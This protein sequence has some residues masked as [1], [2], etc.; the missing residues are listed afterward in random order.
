M[1]TNRQPKIQPDLWPDWRTNKP[2]A[3]AL[4]LTFAFLIVFLMAK[5]AESLR[6]AERIGK[7]EPYEHQITVDGVGKATSLS[8]ADLGELKD[9]ARA[10]AIA[11]AKDK[12]AAISQTLGVQ[13]ERV[14]GYSE[15]TDDGFLPYPFY[16]RADDSAGVLPDAET[17]KDEVTL[18][19]SI[20]Y[21]LVD[22]LQPF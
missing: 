9:K 20:T 10:K 2:Y 3:L 18:N 14:V 17:N 5:T 12:A 19:V 21:K 16:D 6:V 22:Y 4:L 8:G 13:L 1:P 7:P 11:D 15:W